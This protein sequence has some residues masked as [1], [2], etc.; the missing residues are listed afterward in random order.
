LA[1]VKGS[2]CESKVNLSLLTRLEFSWQAVI[3]TQGAPSAILGSVVQRLRR[4]EVALITD[5]APVD[6]R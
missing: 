5:F 6:D 1:P 4:Q 3:Q 2:P